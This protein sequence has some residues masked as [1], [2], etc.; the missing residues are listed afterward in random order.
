MVIAV[1]TGDYGK[2]RPALV[3]QSD[4][5]NETHSS[6]VICPI[7]S[8]STGLTL[9]RISL[10]A[11]KS[12]GLRDESEIMIDK[13]TAV[14]RGRLRRR[15][16]RLTATQMLLVNEALARWLELDQPVS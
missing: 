2:P 15:I 7:T 9:F 11:S 4:L 5:F 16:G 10:P 13:M 12:T 1:L 3:I 14:A 8:E 6:L